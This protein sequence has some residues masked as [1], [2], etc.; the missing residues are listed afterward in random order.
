MPSKGQ[1]LKLL[2]TESS[3]T[4]RMHR[5]TIAEKLGQTSYRPFQ[6]QLD[7]FERQGLIEGNEEHEYYLTDA[8]KIDLESEATITEDEFNEEKLGSTEFQKFISL[9]KM[10][11]VSPVELI[12]QTAQHVWAGG[13]YNDLEWVARAFQEMGIRQDLRNRWWHSWRSFLQ[14]PLPQQLPEAIA[15]SGSNAEG[16]SEVKK[17]VRTHILDVDDK[18]VYVGEGYGDM[19]EADALELAKIRAGRGG[20]HGSVAGS[21]T[22]GSM[23][24]EMVKLFTAFQQFKG[25]EA[26]GKSYMVRQGEEGLQVEEVDP[27]RPMVI[28]YPQGENKQKTTYF[29]GPDGETQEVQPGQPI[30]IKQASAPSSGAV[31]QYLIDKNSGQ[32]T[33]VKPGQPI[34]IQASAP[35]QP[36]PYTPIQMKDKDGN[37]MVLDLSTF[38]RLEEHKDKQR[39]DE[40]S[41]QVKLEIAKGFMGMLG[42]ASKA[43]GHVVEE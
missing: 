16:K 3:E 17:K 9:G 42:R 13:K 4:N 27:G 31:M 25:D 6:S 12:M 8:G 38:I 32:V 20:R 28:N 40:E 7:R 23:A 11:G 43:L 2:A 1:I 41:H 39:R 37:P 26:R 15:E 22:P 34:V 29:V 14:E 19:S 5:N 35:Q 24:D 33:E 30:I 36:Y 10:T 18:P 21:Q